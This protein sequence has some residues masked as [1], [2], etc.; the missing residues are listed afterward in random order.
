MYHYK[1][2]VEFECLEGFDLQ[3]SSTVF[4]G[5]NDNWE[6]QMPT[7]IKGTKGIFF[8]LVCF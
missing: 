4:C 1:A 6:P 3:G 5:S 7:C 8:L 2:K